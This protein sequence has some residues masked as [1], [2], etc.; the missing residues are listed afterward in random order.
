MQMSKVTQIE[1]ALLIRGLRSFISLNESEAA[2]QEK[3][4]KQ[5]ESE[6]SQRYGMTLREP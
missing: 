1:L 3:L 6:L 5:L 4:L 2:A